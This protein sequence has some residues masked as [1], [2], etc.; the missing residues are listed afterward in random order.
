MKNPVSRRCRFSRHWWRAAGGEVRVQ[1][2]AGKLERITPPGFMALTAPQEVQEDGL[3][4]DPFPA[5][6][7][8]KG[9]FR[10][11]PSW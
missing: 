6:A 10:K 11:T 7:A 2:E 8:C 3:V 9:Y 1:Q 4:A 5:P